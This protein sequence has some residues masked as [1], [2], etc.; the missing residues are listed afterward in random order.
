MSVRVLGFHDLKPEKNIPWT[1]NHIYR[2]V[3]LGKFPRPFK[4]GDNTNA[5]DE[6]TIDEWIAN[7]IKER[8]RVGT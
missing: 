5:W 2:L 6:D 7:K 4:L 1:R 8:A 3:R